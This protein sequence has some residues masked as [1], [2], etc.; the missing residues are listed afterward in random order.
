VVHR[1][2]IAGRRIVLLEHIRRI[3]NWKIGLPPEALF[4]RTV[5]PPPRLRRYGGHPS[6]EFMSEGWRRRPDLNRD[7]G[8]ADFAGFSILLIRLVSL[9]SGTPRFSL[10][11]G[12]SWTEI[13]LKWQLLSP[14]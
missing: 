9:V 7:G 11:F 2:P 6:R 14:R 4:E 8:F 3:L 1:S 12:R 5:S 10:V 13:G